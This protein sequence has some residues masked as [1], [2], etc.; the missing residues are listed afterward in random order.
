MISKRGRKNALN[1]QKSQSKKPKIKVAKL[2]VQKVPDMEL[3]RKVQL[4]LTLKEKSK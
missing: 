2:A 1:M 3:V 4:G